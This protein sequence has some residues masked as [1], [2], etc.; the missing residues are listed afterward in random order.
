VPGPVP[1]PAMVVEGG[2]VVVPVGGTV[3]VIMV[4]VVWITEVMEEIDVVETT[5]TAPGR[6]WE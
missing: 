6:H 4:V 2:V 5:D 1:D 3:V